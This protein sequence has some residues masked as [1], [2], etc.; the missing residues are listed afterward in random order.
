MMYVVLQTLS[1]RNGSSS[2][3]AWTL[4]AQPKLLAVLS[5]LIFG[6]LFVSHL[7]CTA[8]HVLDSGDGGMQ[9]GTGCREDWKSS[10]R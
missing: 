1:H 10:R 9:Q 7:L 5:D 2:I 4:N 6:G 8:F 3:L